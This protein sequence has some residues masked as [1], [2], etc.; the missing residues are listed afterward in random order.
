MYH[1]FWLELDTNC[2][3]NLFQSADGFRQSDE[4]LSSGQQLADPSGHLDFGNSSLCVS[5]HPMGGA[6][7]GPAP[8][9]PLGASSSGSHDRYSS[10]SSHHHGAVAPPVPNPQHNGDR[11]QPVLHHQYNSDALNGYNQDGQDFQ[12]LE[13]SS[14]YIF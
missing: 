8:Q 13:V 6:S 9:V 7:V 4:Y 14:R 11:F 5:D 10:G 1:C 2:V 12:H 3:F